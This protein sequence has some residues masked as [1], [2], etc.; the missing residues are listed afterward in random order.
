MRVLVVEDDPD[1]CHCL[2]PDGHTVE[3]VDNGYD[4]LWMA[5]EFDFD[6]VVLEWSLPDT[7]GIDARRTL[8]ERERWV[9][10]LM[11]TANAAIHQRDLGLSSG[12]DDYLTKPFAVD[13]LRARALALGRRA[14][15]KRPTI[16]TVGDLALDPAS[17]MVRR[18]D[19]PIALRPKEFALTST[20]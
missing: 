8:R 13:E 16:L 3:A 10:I 17:R 18:G 15:R 6:L 2:A 5:T 19:Q 11:F 12:S 9:P 1:I 14:P 4:G 20:A 7:N